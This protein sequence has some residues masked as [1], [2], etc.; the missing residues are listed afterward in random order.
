MLQ[1]SVRKWER[2][3]ALLG[4]SAIDER[5]LRDREEQINGDNAYEGSTAAGWVDAS[6]HFWRGFS[7]AKARRFRARIEGGFPA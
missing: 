6:G 4:E 1:T 5:A 2:Q 3:G 7:Q